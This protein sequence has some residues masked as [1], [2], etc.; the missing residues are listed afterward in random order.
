MM[1][2]D[3]E[4]AVELAPA[5]IA[6]TSLAGY[7]LYA[8]KQFMTLFEL[9]QKMLAAGP[10]IMQV[11]GHRIS[12]SVLEAA[13]S[14]RQVQHLRISMSSQQG[15][16][17]ELLCSISC[18]E[19]DSIPSCLIF[20]MQNASVLVKAQNRQLAETTALLAAQRLAG[21]FS[22]RLLVD[23]LDDMSRNPVYW[24][25]EI[26]DLLGETSSSLS[27]VAQSYLRFVVAE[28]KKPFLDAI[29]SAILG[30]SSYTF[31]YGLHHPDGSLRTMR[32][33]GTVVTDELSKLKQVIGIEVDI[34]QLALQRQRSGLQ[35]RRLSTLM[36]ASEGPIYMVDRKLCYIDFNSMHSSMILAKHGVSIGIGASLLDVANDPATRR[37]LRQIFSRVFKGEQIA[38]EVHFQSE[39]H[40]PA[41]WMDFCFTPIIAEDG[42]IEG[43]VV[44]GKEISA[45]KQVKHR[46]EHLHSDLEHMVSQRTEQLASASA[47]LNAL[48]HSFVAHLTISLADLASALSRAQLKAQASNDTN[49]EW[50]EAAHAEVR[51]MQSMLSNILSLTRVVMHT[52]QPTLVD[53]TQLV[54]GILREMATSLANH[55]VEL[56]KLPVIQTDSMLLGQILN[57]LLDNAAR[58]SCQRRPGRIRIKTDRQTQGLV[59]SVT[60]NGI[61]FAATDAARIFAPFAQLDTE[62]GKQGSGLGLTV[63]KR[64]IQK[65]GGRIWPE[66]TQNH[67][68]TIYFVIDAA[69]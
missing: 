52:P 13:F 5:A 18:A 56:S 34:T 3:T 66:S 58:F 53:A 32:S 20:V 24:S 55:E 43:A 38:E 28:D 44:I 48:M 14:L 21:A 25:P 1:S 37:K 63:A 39:G 64:A 16:V 33:S 69:K 12:Q 15:E 17:E 29:R 40:L 11:T 49:P 46:I 57:C 27:K 4:T 59:W 26:Y 31:I 8:N 68:T 50:L 61:G 42:R 7:M 23:D 65:L 35:R 22:W 41:R 10:D 45:L 47:E 54:Q 6:V 2:L 67:G 19:Q 60:D 36:E 62:L 51:R 30:N 9:E